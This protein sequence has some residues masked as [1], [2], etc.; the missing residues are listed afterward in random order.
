MATGKKFKP[1]VMTRRAGFKNT[2]HSAASGW[3]DS[4]V[5]AV[6]AGTA[7][8]SHRLAVHYHGNP[9]H[10]QN[11]LSEP[12]AARPSAEP[13]EPQ[14]V[15][16]ADDM[17]RKLDATAYPAAHGMRSRTGEGGVVPDKLG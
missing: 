13:A 3:L 1:P 7:A 4:V 16:D 5:N 11:D 14:D 6:K 10:L 8:A 2:D 17:V 15:P 12:I 9:P